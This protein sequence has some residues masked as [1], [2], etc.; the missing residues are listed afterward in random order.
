LRLTPEKKIEKKNRALDCAWHFTHDPG[1]V[2][3]SRL[4]SVLTASCKPG[5]NSGETCC[6]ASEG[7]ETSLPWLDPPLFHVGR[8]ILVLEKLSV[9]FLAECI[10]PVRAFKASQK[11]SK[12]YC[13][14]RFAAS[15]ASK[16]KMFWIKMWC[17]PMGPGLPTA[18]KFLGRFPKIAILCEAIRPRKERGR[19]SW[20]NWMQKR[21]SPISLNLTISNYTPPP[22]KKNWFN[23]V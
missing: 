20:Q 6:I 12:T 15:S 11:P 17:P 4:L 22:P 3:F 10:T 14:A 8:W 18:P 21:H 2:H 19:N 13:I 9:V 1:F 7:L 5:T 23:D 16:P